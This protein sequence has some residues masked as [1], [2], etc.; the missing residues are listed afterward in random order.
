[1]K[2]S[3]AKM[4]SIAEI[5]CEAL[6]KATH[7][8]LL[9]VA[10]PRAHPFSSSIIGAE[11]GF[12]RH[13]AIDSTP[14]AKPRAHPSSMGS[15][16]T[17]LSIAKRPC[18]PILYWC[19]T[20]LVRVVSPHRSDGARRRS[21]ERAGTE[22][23]LGVHLRRRLSAAA[24]PALRPRSPSPTRCTIAR[25]DAWNARSTSPSQPTLPS[26]NSNTRARARAARCTNCEGGA[27]ARVTG[28]QFPTGWPKIAGRA[29]AAVGCAV[30]R[31]ARSQAL[32]TAREPHRTSPVRPSH[33][34]SR[35]RG[36]ASGNAPRAAAR[37]RRGIPSRKSQ[38]TVP[39]GWA[40]AA[41]SAPTFHRVR[42]ARALPYLCQEGVSDQKASV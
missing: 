15:H 8:K 28:G 26:R 39:P 25:D 23:A 37:A 3:H 32:S 38:G 35:G 14:I 2:A 19:G 36:S 27:A 11:K 4:L 42:S 16:G 18:E 20:L 22:R 17:L 31:T 24:H 6:K 1:M 9:S 33:R 30:P 12:A 13:F 41:R 10:K 21:G 7:A 34:R 5:P 29:P 40:I